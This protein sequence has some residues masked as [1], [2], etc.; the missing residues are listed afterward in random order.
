MP[1]LNRGATELLNGSG[2]HGG[3]GCG[4]SGA[5][6]GSPELTIAQRLAPPPPPPPAGSVCSAEA[7]AS[8]W[9]SAAAVAA[10]SRAHAAPAARGYHASAAWLADVTVEVPSMGESITEGTV[11]VILKQP[12]SR[13]AQQGL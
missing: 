13:V 6:H 5:A 7:P 11:A 4:R 9:A 3:P 2:E 12:G 8:R 10:A 1:L